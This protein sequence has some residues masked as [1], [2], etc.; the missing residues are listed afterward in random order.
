M[1]RPFPCFVIMT[2][3]L[4]GIKCLEQARSCCAPA[5]QWETSTLSASPRP[6]GRGSHCSAWV[7]PADWALH[8]MRPESKAMDTMSEVSEG[9]TGTSVSGRGSTYSEDLHDFAL[10]IGL[11]GPDQ[12]YQDRFRVDRRKLELMIRG[13][14]ST[15][16]A[17][18]N[19]LALIN[20]FTWTT[21]RA[22]SIYLLNFTYISN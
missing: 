15:T 9:T 14:F 7:E 3:I 16:K 12:L 22:Y 1:H 8:R 10:Q 17:L 19:Y 13:V 11:S 21:S 6:E 5:S 20:C 2:F 4:C 18:S